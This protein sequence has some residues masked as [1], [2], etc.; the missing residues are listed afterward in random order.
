MKF[1]N[2]TPHVLNISGQT[3]PPDG[4]I[5]RVSVSR[6]EKGTVDG[7]PLFVPTFG[8]VIGLPEHNWN[9]IYIVSSLVRSHPDVAKRP[10]VCSPGSPVRDSEGKIVGADGLD[11]NF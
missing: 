5:A 6:K 9:N 4:T 11:F 7:I 8:A 3:I 10:D 2:L 1:V